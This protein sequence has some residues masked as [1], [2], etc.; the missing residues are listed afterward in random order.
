MSDDKISGNQN[1]TTTTPLKDVKVT[2]ADVKNLTKPQTQS[3]ANQ[4]QKSVQQQEN[5]NQQ[6]KELKQSFQVEYDNVQ[7]HIMFILVVAIV[8][9]FVS[10]IALMYFFPPD[11]TKFSNV[12][13]ILNVLLGSLATAFITIVNFYFGSSSGSKAK[14]AA[15][16]ALIKDTVDNQN[17]NGGK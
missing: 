8:G 9:G 15:N 16:I 1:N 17:N 7:R 5:V 4:I 14:D 3:E 2:D 11:P 12:K 6:T 10:I 13:D